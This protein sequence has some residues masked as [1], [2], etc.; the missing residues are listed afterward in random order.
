MKKQILQ[1]IEILAKNILTGKIKLS[2]EEM[3]KISD[4]NN[5][6]GKCSEEE[7]INLLTK[8]NWLNKSSFKKRILS[9]MD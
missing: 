7:S 4:P 3:L 9:K 2:K 1:Q 6:I 5:I 8:S